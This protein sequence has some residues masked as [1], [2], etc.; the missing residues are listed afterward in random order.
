MPYTVC[1][2]SVRRNNLN[3][4]DCTARAGLCAAD[5]LHVPCS[6]V[7]WL[8]PGKMVGLTVVHNTVKVL[9]LKAVSYVIVSCNFKVDRQSPGQ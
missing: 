3:L 4:Y 6:R 7:S 1:S 8:A 9:C 5:G 2:F